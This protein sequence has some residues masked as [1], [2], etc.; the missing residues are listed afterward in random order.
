MRS[1]I[2]CVA[3]NKIYLMVTN[4]KLAVIGHW[5]TLEGVNQDLLSPYSHSAQLV[6]LGIILS[7]IWRTSTF[8]R[9]S[10]SNVLSFVRITTSHIVQAPGQERKGPVDCPMQQMASNIK[11]SWTISFFSCRFEITFY[12][13]KLFLE[14]FLL[15]KTCSKE[16]EINACFADVQTFLRYFN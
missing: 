6:F 13:E 8:T 12:R 1:L 4:H 7:D 10:R 3:Y 2:S 11:W 5:D 15:I 16:S 9:I 14:T